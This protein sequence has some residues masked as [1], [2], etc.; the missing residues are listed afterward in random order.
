M[1]DVWFPEIK[2][3]AFGIS[4]DIKIPNLANILNDTGSGDYQKLETEVKQK[5]HCLR[6][7]CVCV[8]VLCVCVLCVRCMCCV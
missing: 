7:N 6:T 5:V 1:S 2:S 4:V 8:C 3:F